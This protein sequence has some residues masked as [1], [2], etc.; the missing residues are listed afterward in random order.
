MEEDEW[1]LLLY[2]KCLSKDNNGG[3]GGK[4]L[5]FLYTLKEKEDLEFF[6]VGDAS[7]GHI[8]K[9]RS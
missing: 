3:G 4:L 2:S 7:Y 9:D 5:F 1:Y 8:G 6:I